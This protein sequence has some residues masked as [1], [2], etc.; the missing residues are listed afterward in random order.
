[1]KP[2][3]FPPGC[4]G[5][6]PIAWLDA[7]PACQ[8]KKSIGFIRDVMDRDWYKSEEFMPG[9]AA[10]IVAMDIGVSWR[11]CRVGNTL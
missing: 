6:S 5:S 10:G 2:R 3:L 1:M 11:V 4:V 9:H 8:T 7:S